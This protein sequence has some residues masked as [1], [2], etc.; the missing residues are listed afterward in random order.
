MPS[1]SVAEA[2]RADES[3]SAT[4]PSW[5]HVVESGGE[6]EEGEA[7]TVDGRFLDADLPDESSPASA[8]SHD[9]EFLDADAPGEPLDE[10]TSLDTHVGGY[11]DVDSD[12]AP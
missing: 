1:P 12:D 2:T 5:R 8:P 9:G 6:N 10:Q 3:T 4:S 7:G 11:L